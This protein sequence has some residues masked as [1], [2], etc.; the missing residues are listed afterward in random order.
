MNPDKPGCLLC[1]DHKVKL[2]TL[3]NGSRSSAMHLCDEHSEDLEILMDLAGN[4]PSPER[5]PLMAGGYADEGEHPSLIIRRRERERKMEPLDW[6][7]PQNW[8]PTER[9]VREYQKALSSVQ[10]AELVARAALGES[11]RELG[12]EYGISQPAV[13]QYIKD[14]AAITAAVK[15]ALDE[16]PYGRA[17]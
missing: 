15:E 2:W 17:D 14:G 3:D 9:P 5:V 12:K 4:R 10:R 16:L 11:K 6:T 13:Y 1:G 7:P 8:T